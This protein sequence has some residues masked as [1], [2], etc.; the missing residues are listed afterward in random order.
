MRRASRPPLLFTLLYPPPV[1]HLSH[2]IPALVA[3][4]N[5]GRYG[6]AQADAARLLQRHPT[7]A[8]L[9]AI[10]AAAH[11]RQARPE[12]AVFHAQRA[13]SLGSAPEL[14]IEM[15]RILL[16]AAHL[17]PGHIAEAD[18]ALS[19]ALAAAPHLPHAHLALAEARIAQKRYASARDCAA[20]ALALVPHH[21]GALLMA[22]G[23][24]LLTGRANE[25]AE[26]LRRAAQLHPRDPMLASALCLTLH[27][28]SATPAEILAAHQRFA[29]LL[30]PPP[31]RPPIADPR[32]DRPLTIALVSPD[33]VDHPVASFV[34]PLAEH[35]DPSRV[36]LVMY[37][38]I[39]RATP[40]DR[41][42]RCDLW[43]DAG[44]WP[45]D[46]LAQ[47]VR[48]DHVDI[49]VD[50]SGHTAG[51]RLGLFLRRPA[52]VQL[53]WLGYPATTGL[54]VFDARL[55][56]THTDPPSDEAHTTEPLARLDPCFLCFAPPPQPAA[57]LAPPEPVTFVSFNALS[58]INPAV[59]DTWTQILARVPGSRLIIKNAGLAEDQ[60]RR[61]LL[62]R[63]SPILAAHAVDPARIE[64]HGWMN[65]P[66]HLRLY[67][68][69]SLALDTFPYAGTT[70]TCEALAMGIPV[71]TLA[72]QTHAARVGIT[73]LH[74]A[75]LPELIAPDITTYIDRAATLAQSPAALAALRD[76]VQI[77]STTLC[78]GP[79]FAARWESAARDVWTRAVRS[80]QT[81]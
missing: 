44:T 52:P 49:L 73:L 32:P 8:N 2:Q 10:L 71:L 9:H 62:A 18:A 41:R 61:D 58:K 5:A 69:A 31:P 77:R 74:A 1:S 28:T 67:Q 34:A 26:I 20:A 56:D 33:L 50:L 63:W 23:M 38:T 51:H 66:D 80:L 53:T 6:Q 55:V 39:A 60:T 70:T 22:G 45:D 21:P 46:R 12:R 14:F 47:Q 57:S 68:R 76:R 17:A 19:R 25:S 3:L 13:L 78:D 48:A 15:G 81:Q 36:R 16:H 79:A 75:G 30:P 59:L 72:G 29:A 37:S 42:P 35:L 65:K 40:T 11:E 54:S 7:D 27:Y 64:L 43:H 24:A 4:I